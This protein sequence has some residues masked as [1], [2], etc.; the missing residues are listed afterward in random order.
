MSLE[1]SN[2]TPLD[3]SDSLLEYIHSFSEFP[4]IA[5]FQTLHKKAVTSETNP[6][7]DQR[8]HFEL[9]FIP[10]HNSL[11]HKLTPTSVGRPSSAASNNNKKPQRWHPL[12]RTRIS[13]RSRRRGSRWERRRRLMNIISLV[14]GTYV[15][16]PRLRNSSCLS[17]VSTPIMFCFHSLVSVFLLLGGIRYQVWDHSWFPHINQ[18]LEIPTF[19][20]RIQYPFRMLGILSKRRS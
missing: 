1:T 5:S 2:R 14:C 12:A 10:F 18:S 4:Q 15:L 17:R 7:A 16:S 3:D 6:T 11:S 8:Q 9:S 20:P 19:V 13:F